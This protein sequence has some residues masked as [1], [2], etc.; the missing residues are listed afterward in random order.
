MIEQD[1]VK[2]DF[3]R[4][5]NKMVHRLELGPGGGGH[6]RLVKCFSRSAAGS[7]AKTKPEELRP[8]NICLKTADYLINK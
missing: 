1:C 6:L 5:K 7:Q 3:S 4:L 8:P 2:F